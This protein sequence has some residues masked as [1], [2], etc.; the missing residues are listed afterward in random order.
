MVDTLVQKSKFPPSLAPIADAEHKI[1]VCSLW[2]KRFH[3]FQKSAENLLWE[4]IERKNDQSVAVQISSMS[5][6]DFKIFTKEVQYAKANLT[7]GEFV[8]TEAKIG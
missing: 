4:K 6:C 1:F 5:A 8:R 7:L 3:F 2:K